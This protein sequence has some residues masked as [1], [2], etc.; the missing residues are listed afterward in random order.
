M[1][2]IRRRESFEFRGRLEIWKEEQGRGEVLER[3]GKKKKQQA[4]MRNP[5]GEGVARIGIPHS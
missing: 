1:R 5:R 2:D 4:D 3:K